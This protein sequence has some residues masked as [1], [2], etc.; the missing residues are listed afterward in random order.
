MARRRCSVALLP[1]A[2]LLAELQS[3]RR[4]LGDPRLDVLAAHVTV[5]APV[6]LPGDQLEAATAALRSGA[7]SIEPFHV[8]LGPLASFAPATPT[9][10][11][12][13]SGDTERLDALRRAVRRAPL[14]RP[15][16]R[17]FVPHVTLRR[18]VDDPAVLEG[19]LAALAGDVGSWTI[20][21]VVLLEHRSVHDDPTAG[22][23]ADAPRRWRPIAEEPLGVP[24]VVGRGG[25]ELD[26]RT[27]TVVE[28][29]VARLSGVAA[30]T[31]TVTG[32]DRWVTV[33]ER[34]PDGVVGA[35]VGRIDGR[36]AGI[37]A[38]AVGAGH[39]GLGVARHLVE[40]WCTDAARSGVR[41]AEGAVDGAAAG[42]LAAC[43]FSELRDRW[44]R[45][46]RPGG[47]G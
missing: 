42:V 38:I 9:L 24:V 40:R 35:L 13:V 7:R 19:A 37:D 26:L 41:I 34:A 8:R 4:L 31:D 21:R 16:R 36:W 44:L 20:D 27:V 22:V 47:T 2:P 29:S 11:L 46:L 28:P 1:P 17:A 10:H 25:V 39:R 30:P 6:D 43:G 5:V 3:I 15:D 32:R 12:A 18:S 14:D 33:A 23:A 45:L